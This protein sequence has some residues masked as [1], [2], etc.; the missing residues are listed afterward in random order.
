MK[1]QNVLSEITSIHINVSSG[2]RR[3]LYDVIHILK[4]C[5]SIL[6][7]VKVESTQINN[8]TTLNFFQSSKRGK[9][10]K[11][12]FSLYIVLNAKND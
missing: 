11:G 1:T 10:I 6:K 12:S 7:M 3:P 9:N 8:K 2:L 4:I 5:L